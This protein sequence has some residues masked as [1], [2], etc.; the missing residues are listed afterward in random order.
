[1]RKQITVADALSRDRTIIA[2]CIIAITALAWLYLIHLSGEMSIARSTMQA[3]TI[4]PWSA[5]DYLLTFAMWSVMMVG[6]M[7]PTATPALLLFDGMQKNA[8]ARERYTKVFLFG[9]GYIIVW[10]AFSAL[11]AL[12][13]WVLHDR[14]ILSMSM[15]TTSSRLGGLILLLAGG[16]QLTPAKNVCLRQCQTPLGFLMTNWRE[17]ERGALAMGLKHG[18]YC[19]GCCWAL[20]LVLLVVGVMNLAWVAVLTAFILI[21]KFGRTGSLVARLGGAA[22]IAGGIATLILR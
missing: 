10:I 18:K 3:M 1:V 20:M 13:Q 22:M 16:Y 5:T 4:A 21:E 7:S 11:A 15:A 17:G 2:S 9:L 19:L 14:A 12:T 6:M 8:E